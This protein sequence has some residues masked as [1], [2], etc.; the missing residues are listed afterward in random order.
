MITEWL[1]S[2]GMV[3]SDWFAGLFPD[4]DPPVFLATF[5]TQINDLLSKLSGVG[6]WADWTY[7]LVVVSAVLAAWALGF[8]IKIVLRIAAFI[9]LVGG[10]G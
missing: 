3:L 10:A 4:W 6:V 2:L 8:V 5:D 7:I 1:F 9:P